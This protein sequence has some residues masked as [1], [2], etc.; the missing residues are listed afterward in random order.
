MQKLECGKLQIQIVEASLTRDTELLGK[1]DPYC[2][3]H[4]HEDGERKEFKTETIHGGGKNPKW[5]LCDVH[6]FIV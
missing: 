5:K 1:M 3:A 2:K 4:W 6:T